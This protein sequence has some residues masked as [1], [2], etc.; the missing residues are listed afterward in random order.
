MKEL[1]AE[2]PEMARDI[3]KIVH[4]ASARY[5][6]TLSSEAQ[7]QREMTAKLGHVLKRRKTVHAASARAAEPAA[8]AA[9]AAPNHADLHK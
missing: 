2:K 7:Q 6:E 4:C 3:F 8:E 9:P 1:I 5:A